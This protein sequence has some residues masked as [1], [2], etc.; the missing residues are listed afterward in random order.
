MFVGNQEASTE[1]GSRQSGQKNTKQEHLF[2]KH[3][4]RFSFSLLVFLVVQGVIRRQISAQSDEQ[5]SL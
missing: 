1:S 4:F 2:I 5:L 3:N